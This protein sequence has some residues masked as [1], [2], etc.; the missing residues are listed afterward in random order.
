M[1]LVS[2]HDQKR[3]RLAAGWVRNQGKNGKKTTPINS[4]TRLFKN[5]ELKKD[6][7][8]PDLPGDNSWNFVKHRKVK[9][10]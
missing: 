8:N 7:N 5:I 9:V 1:N 3:Y 10:D 6:G 2:P 4:L